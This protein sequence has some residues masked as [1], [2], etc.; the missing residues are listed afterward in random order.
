[1]IQPTLLTEEE[2]GQVWKEGLITEEQADEI[3]ESLSKVVTEGTGKAA[4]EADFP[5]SG[6]TGTAELKLTGE[7]SG[8]ENSWFVGYPTD[9]QDLM[10]AI[11]VEGTKNHD[12][13]SGVEKATKILIDIKD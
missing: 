11:M 5:I 12:R 10:I 7:D 4:K 1:M 8:D 9:D 2:T 13:S 6:K 3:Q